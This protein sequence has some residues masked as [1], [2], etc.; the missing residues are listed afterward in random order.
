MTNITALASLVVIISCLA[1]QF[2][3]IFFLPG[4]TVFAYVA[5]SLLC[6]HFSLPV[7]KGCITSF[8]CFSN[9][10]ETDQRYLILPNNL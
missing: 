9:K 6:N 5:M 10:V 3:M 7:Y 8:I 2:P 1:N 4:F